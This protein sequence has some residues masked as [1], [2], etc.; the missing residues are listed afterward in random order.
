MR[1]LWGAAGLILALCLLAGSHVA[2]L[3]ELTGSLTGQLEQAR[4]CLLREEWEPAR[5]AVDRARGRWEACGLYLHTTL[6]HAAIDDIRAGFQEAWAYL[7]AREDASEC[8]AVC[9]RLIHQL[10][11]LLEEERPSLKNIL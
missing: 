7:E 4:S 5:Q 11:L 10:E 3:E 6:R 8:A 9:A 2:A 1:R